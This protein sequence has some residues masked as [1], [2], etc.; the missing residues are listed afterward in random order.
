MGGRVKSARQLMKV[1]D[2]INKLM[3]ACEGDLNKSVMLLDTKDREWV[4]D[5]FQIYL[6]GDSGAVVVANYDTSKQQ[7]RAFQ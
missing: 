3:I 4:Y 1:H 2:L 7:G 6:E 5:Y